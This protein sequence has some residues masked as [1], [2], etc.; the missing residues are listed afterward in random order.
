VSA[1]GQ[2]VIAGVLGVFMVVYARDVRLRREGYDLLR[3]A[4]EPAPAT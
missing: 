2:I 1:I 3:A 4:S